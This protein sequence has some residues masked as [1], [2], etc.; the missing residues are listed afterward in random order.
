METPENEELTS[1]IQDMVDQTIEG[2]IVWTRSNPTTFVWSKK[3]DS[4]N[5]ALVTIQK[6]E[7]RVQRVS[8]LGRQIETIEN[9]I[10]QVVESASRATLIALNTEE[11]KNFKDILKKLFEVASVSI[12][13]KGVNFLK[14]ALGEQTA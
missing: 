13:K 2:K 12:S 7:K 5:I 11:D 14:R 3:I 10:F 8:S 1:V 4:A 6:V 9:H